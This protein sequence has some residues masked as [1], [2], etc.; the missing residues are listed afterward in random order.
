[1]EEHSGFHPETTLMQ[2]SSLDPERHWTQNHTQPPVGK[3]SAFSGPHF[4]SWLYAENSV[5]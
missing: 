2:A 1:M 5:K 3:F 4:P